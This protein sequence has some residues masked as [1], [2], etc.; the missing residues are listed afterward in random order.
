MGKGRNSGKR[1]GAGEN[2]ADALVVELLAHITRCRQGTVK[3]KVGP[4]A[5]APVACLNKV[6]DL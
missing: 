1:L 5:F 2:A 6:H 4:P 3:V